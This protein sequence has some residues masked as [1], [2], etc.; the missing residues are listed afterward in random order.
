MYIQYDKLESRVPRRRVCRVVSFSDTAC[1]AAA[2][3]I[4]VR[5]AAPAL[6]IFFN[7]YHEQ[8]IHFTTD[9]R[10]SEYMLASLSSSTPL[11]P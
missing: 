7:P 11:G 9:I 4:D 5:T 1:Y 3:Y 10:C 6:S 8:R 2:T